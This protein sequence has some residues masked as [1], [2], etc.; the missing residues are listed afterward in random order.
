MK[1]I[2]TTLK[3]FS[4][5][6]ELN[7]IFPNTDAFEYTKKGVIRAVKKPS[8]PHC[9]QQCIRNGWD[10][11]TRKDLFT[12]KIG[13]FYCHP[14]KETVR[15][16]LSFWNRFIE[17]W[18]D[19]LSSFFLHLADRDVAVRVISTVMEFITPLSKDSVLR[20]IF[21]AIQ[22]LVIPKVK[23]KFQIVHYDEQHP[24]KGR[25]QRYRLTLMCAI[26]GQNIADEQFEEINPEIVEGFLAKYLDTNKETVIITDHCPWYPEVFKRLWGNKVKHQ[27]CLL[28]LNKLIMKDSGRVKTLQ[29]MYNTYL[30]L[31]IFFDRSKELQFL[32]MLM[33]EAKPHSQDKEWLAHARKRFN[34]FVRSLE[35]MRRRNK[36]NLTLRSLMSAEMKF[37]K[38]KLE[39]HL[40]NKPLR[41]RLAYIEKHWNQFILFYTIEDCPHTNNIIENYF[42]SSLKTHRKKQF[43]TDKGID[44][45]LKLARY[46]RNVGLPLPQRSFLTWGRWFFILGT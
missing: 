29:E 30:L 16:D 18:E 31:D 1:E 12:L 27:L 7:T 33:D 41:K 13:K 36:K 6:N 4:V 43:R 3:N 2:E 19:T 40:L 35:K 23:Q 24:K 15:S 28:H 37:S 39:Q 21:S 10:T 17:E 8:C 34:R 11:L 32:A 45:K 25:D 20:R 42:S 38:L 44:Y 14:C 26:T 5:I 46:K 22:Q 9:G